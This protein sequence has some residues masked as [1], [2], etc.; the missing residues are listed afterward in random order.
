MDRYKPILDFIEKDSSSVHCHWSEYTVLQLKIQKTLEIVLQ[1]MERSNKVPSEAVF[2]F[3]AAIKYL[4]KDY[5]ALD[6]LEKSNSFQNFISEKKQEILE[7]S[8][9]RKVQANIPERAFPI[10]E[11]IQQY[12]PNTK[13]NIIE[14]GAS[15]GLLGQCLLHLKSALEKRKSLFLLDQKLPKKPSQISNYLGIEIDPPEKEWLLASYPDS[16][17][18]KRINNFINSF[19]S[20]QCFKV[21]KSSAFG[22]SGLSE[23]QEITKN[24]SKTIILTS[25]MLYQLDEKNQIILK[26]EIKKFIG[27]YDGHWI[28]QDVDFKKGMDKLEYYI[29]LDEETIIELEDDLCKNWNWLV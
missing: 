2:I 18:A 5:D 6:I 13:V 4:H 15:Y 28:N 1:I 21:I 20:H 17:Y 23:T 24:N 26:D 9:N 29:K 22:F 27:K 7:I 16:A 8:I 12:C 3:L 19:S 10:A 14:L 25:F 11:I